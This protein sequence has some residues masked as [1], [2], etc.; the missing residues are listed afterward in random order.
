MTSSQKGEPSVRAID[1]GVEEDADGDDLA[2]DERG[3]GRQRQL[4]AQR[5]R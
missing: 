5:L 1:A 2:D 3:G 4:T